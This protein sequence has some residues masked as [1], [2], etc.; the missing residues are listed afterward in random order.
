MIAIW[1]DG[2]IWWR[3]RCYLLGLP[4]RA[5]KNTTCPVKSELNNKYFFRV[6]RSEI[7]HG[8]IKNYSLF[9]WNLILTGLDTVHLC[10]CVYMH[11]CVMLNGSLNNLCRHLS[12][13]HCIRFKTVWLSLF[14]EKGHIELCLFLTWFLGIYLGVLL[15]CFSIQ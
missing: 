9:I 10:V 12:V 3:N 13:M 7:F 14:W 15:I 2:F 4:D 11:T 6:S 5:N 1:S 8:T